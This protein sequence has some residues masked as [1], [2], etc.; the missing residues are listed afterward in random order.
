MD[1]SGFLG[2]Y[3]PFDA[4]DG[5]ALARVASAVE[6]EHFP[7]GR[8][9]LA[10]AGEPAHA[11]YVIRKGAVELLDDGQLLDLLGEGE[12]FGQFSLL[13]AVGPSVTV[14][15]HEDTLCY[16]I[17]RPVADELLG[18][19]AGRSFV[20]GSM[21]RRIRS[22]TARQHGEPP[23][24]RYREIAGL[25]ARPPVTADPQTSVRDAAELMTRAHVSSLLIP[26]DGGWG[27]LT[28]RDLRS[29]VV[30]A[31]APDDSPV[32]SVA[33]FP[34]KTM[35]GSTLAGEALLAMFAEG[36]HHFPVTGPGGELL[37]V[38]TDTDLM[39][40]GRHTPFALK[41]AIERAGD[42]DQ[43]IVAGK[44]LPEVV[45]ALVESHGD[46]VDVGRV[47]S[48]AIDAM[49]S[50][51]LLI[52]VAEF[53]EPP[54]PWAWLAL[55]SQARHEQ[56]LHTDQDHALAYDPQEADPE[57]I[58]PY[59]AKLAEFVTDGLEAV[60]IPKCHGDA[61]A[62]HQLL[63]RSLDGWVEALRRWTH[64]P[65]V[66]GSILSSI[67]FDFRRVAGPLDV[68]P[69]MNA[70]VTEAKDMPAFLR[71]LSRRALDRKPPTGFMR[72]LVVAHSGEH[73]GRLDIKRG[74]ITIVG[75][76]ARAA[77]V[78][79]GLPVK[80]TLA[81]LEGSAAA[82]ALDPD[83][84]AE[85][86]EAFR[87]LWEVRLHHQVTQVRADAPPD[88]FLDPST[89]GSLARSGLKEAFRVIARAQR[90]LASELGID[91]P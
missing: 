81:R 44:D 83:I 76:L 73:E 34:A 74:G 65:G 15:A 6:I 17:R 33:T 50:Q 31:R 60:G 49:T 87:F 64:E 55:G 3:P 57:T 21:R 89:L 91:V 56:A 75:N 22:A 85:L 77:A 47:I 62:S 4:L 13:A 88:D 1:I 51:L 46:P 69:A 82:G 72:D 38:V 23:D 32:E 26:K 28:D 35:A 53:G 14:R 48:I 58:D 52:G 71:H 8:V 7:A 67:V 9:I 79:A 10:Q 5:A 86:A 36:V 90:G 70:V 78:G 20:I 30:A 84:A 59:F 25:I 16:L 39:D 80:G 40:I 11:L 45:C 68:E 29:R 42:R 24:R 43:V 41:R 37:G 61:M 12:L 18:T 2:R 27:I 19:A 63:R 54:V 66:D